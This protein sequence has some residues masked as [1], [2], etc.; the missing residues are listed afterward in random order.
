MS[1]RMIPLSFETLLCTAV[2]ELR[3]RNT[4]FGVPVVRPKACPV[5]FCGGRL[6]TPIGPA[7]GPH[8]QLANNLVAAYGAGGRIF[9]LKT[10]QV[11]DG[12]D[13]P[14][15]KPCIYVSGE[16][17]NVE[18]STELTIKQAA[19]EYIKA[20]LVIRLLA[21]EFDLGDPEGFQFHMSVGYDL[22]GLQS[23]KVDR[24][25][26]TMKDASRSPSWS[27]YLSQ[28]R[29]HLELFQVVNEDYVNS[30]PTQI[31]NTVTLSTLHGCPVGE[32]RRMI[33]YLL[34]EKGLNT[35]VKCNPTL[36]GY[37]TARRVLDENGYGYLAFDREGFDRDLQPDYAVE[38][39][40]DLKALADSLGLTLGVK[41]TNTFPVAIRNGELPGETMYLSGKPLFLLSIRTAQLLSQAFEGM[42]PVSFS[43]GIDAH[44]VA[45]VLSVGIAPVTVATLLLQ[46]G[47]YKNLSRL[48][49]LAPEEIPERVDVAALDAL[50]DTV[51]ADPYYQK[52]QE[53]GT[54]KRPLD[55][56]ACYKCRNCVDVCPNRANLALP[57]LK[58]AVHIESLCNECGNCACLCP[59]GYLPYRDKFTLFDDETTMEHS[60]NDGFYLTGE[61][62]VARVNGMEI[63]ALEEL[64]EELRPVV[65]TFL[66]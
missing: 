36:V 18:W 7:A 26:E 35:F 44:N 20:W 43:G 45:Q 13:L 41:L 59:F 47:G 53:R 58:K 9:E 48:C 31:C 66:G 29:A 39:L 33:A 50:V 63:C 15:E 51:A 2:K 12:E 24:F 40:T 14:V 4:L 61:G 46:Q 6:E 60:E 30:I 19:A 56:L 65:T 8:T 57:E 54:A 10:V 17:Y 22:A 23:E 16:A 1:D 49:A 37:D 38:L 28:I 52:R 27:L 55:S 21:R 25:I 11:I 42:L 32:I 62:F 34:E 64:P 3:E 5:D